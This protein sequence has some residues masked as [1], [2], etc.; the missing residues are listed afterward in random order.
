VRQAFDCGPESRAFI[1]VFN[2]EVAG[3]VEY[4]AGEDPVK[5]PALL[6][7]PVIVDQGSVIARRPF[8]VCNSG[9]VPRKPEGT[10][11]GRRVAVNKMKRRWR[12]G[13]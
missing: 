4:A 11:E 12:E 5:G 2:Q 6:K 13:G 8:D 7:P 3:V 10:P 1:H 9:S